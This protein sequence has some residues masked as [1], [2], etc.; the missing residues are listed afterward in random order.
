MERFVA[1]KRANINGKW[2]FVTLTEEE[3]TEALG[4]LLEFNINELKR[5]IILTKASTIVAISQ[6]DAVKLLFERQG[7]SSFTYLNNVLDEKIEKL[8][9]GSWE[10]PER[11]ADF[12][13][14]EPIAEAPADVQEEI[15][16][17]DNPF[18]AGKIKDEYEEIKLPKEKKGRFF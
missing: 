15:K 12:G 13:K 10:K 18:E 16:D 14:E 9:E 11:K 4:D 3:I 5:I 8:K 17:E 2:Q 1:A 6:T 7:I